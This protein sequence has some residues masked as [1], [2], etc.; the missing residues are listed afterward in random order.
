MNNALLHPRSHIRLAVVNLLRATSFPGS[1]YP[2]REEPW[3]A[4]E[5][6]AIGVYSASETKL[7]TDISPRP[8]ERRLSLLV[9]IVTK[10]STHVDDVMD[11]FSYLVECALTFAALEARLALDAPSLPLLDLKHVSTELAIADTGH[12]LLGAASIAFDIDYRMPASLPSLDSFIT[13]GIGWDICD[14]DGPDT[15]LEAKDILT[16]PQE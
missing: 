15:N 2:S 11:A 7:E 14:Y 9:D 3:A 13:G 5:L 8:D 12:K 6:P 10:G 1:V 16:L 4:Q